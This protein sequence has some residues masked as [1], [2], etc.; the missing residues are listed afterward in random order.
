[1]LERRDI[2][3]GNPRLLTQIFF[4]LLRINF[5]HHSSLCSSTRYIRALPLIIYF[6]VVTLQQQQHVLL[7]IH[8]NSVHLKSFLKNPGSLLLCLLCFSQRCPGNKLETASAVILLVF[9]SDR[10]RSHFSS[11]PGWI[12]SASSFLA[13]ARHRELSKAP[14]EDAT[15]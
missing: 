4:R 9:S 6:L 2:L 12:Q 15:R 1:M 11:I 13:R 14:I 7:H 8:S 3:I 5:F 10:M